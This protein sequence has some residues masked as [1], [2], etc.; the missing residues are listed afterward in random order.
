MGRSVDL[1]DPKHV[2]RGNI[3]EALCPHIVGVYVSEVVVVSVADE[4]ACVGV[5]DEIRQ[6]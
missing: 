3:R 4:N 2:G 5:A 1:H 6:R